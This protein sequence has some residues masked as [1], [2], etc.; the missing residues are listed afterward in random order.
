MSP[1]TPMACTSNACEFETPPGIPTYELVLK[2]LEVHNQASHNS[3][4]S[5]NSN[6]TE[7]LRRPMVNTGMSE[8]EWTFFVHKWERYT[9]HAKLSEAQKLDELWACMDA[10]IERL[11]FNDGLTANTTTDLL[12]GLKKLSVTELHPS[13]HVM[14]LHEM[15]QARGESTKAFSARVKGTANNC[16]LVK[17][18]TKASCNEQVSFLEE[19]CYHV[20]LAGLQDAQLR[21]KVLTQAM[22][23]N[24]TDLPSLITYTSAEESSKLKTPIS[25]LAATTRSPPKDRLLCTHCGEARH[26]LNNEHRQQKCKAFGKTCQ[27]CQKQGHF[28]S[29]CRSPRAAPV[30]S[31]AQVNEIT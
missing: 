1:P 13:V 18:C 2:C 10:D 7:K 30:Q 28:A 4:K 12:V 11:A 9:R 25:Q 20:V 24:V 17:K 5:E 8:S 29:Q 22:L 31:R 16:N 15:R 27:R 14:A 26:G 3:P 23:N 21:E 19:T 6:K